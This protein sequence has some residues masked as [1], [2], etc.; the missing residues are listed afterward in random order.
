MFISVFVFFFFLTSLIL[1]QW[2]LVDSHGNYKRAQPRCIRREYKPVRDDTSKSLVLLNYYSSPRLN[3]D[4]MNA[5]HACYG[6]ASNRW[7]NF[8]AIHYDKVWINYFW[9]HE[10]AGYHVYIIIVQ[11]YSK[12]TEH[13][14]T[15]LWDETSNRSCEL[16]KREVIMWKRWC[17]ILQGKFFYLFF[18]SIEFNHSYISVP[19]WERR[20]RSSLISSVCMQGGML[21]FMKAV[22]TFVCWV[23]IFVLLICCISRPWMRAEITSIYSTTSSCGDY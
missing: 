20:R 4:L 23:W 6:A 16:F 11:L 5:I 22:F 14:I 19:F 15:G 7:A 3:E 2:I 9:Q 8:I 10:L 17:E 12:T 21:G 1:V 18:I 13:N